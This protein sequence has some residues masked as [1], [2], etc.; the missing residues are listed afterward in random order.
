M[1]L[2]KKLF[3]RK[4]TC[5]ICGNTE[6]SMENMKVISNGIPTSL[7]YSGVSRFHESCIKD[8]ICEPWKY[9]DYEKTIAVRYIEIEELRKEEREKTDKKIK[10]FQ[11]E[12]CN[13]HRKAR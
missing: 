4:Y 11:K 13:E 3:A 2:L 10:Q 9:N 5:D 7:Y 1:N 12:I 8:V 6:Y